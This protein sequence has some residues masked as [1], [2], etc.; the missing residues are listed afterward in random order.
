[1]SITP[2]KDSLEINLKLNVIPVSIKMRIIFERYACGRL[3]SYKK[4]L[5]AG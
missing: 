1:L 5:R 3:A 4:T 2:F